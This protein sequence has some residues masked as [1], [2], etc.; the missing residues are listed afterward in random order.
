MSVQ[1]EAVGRSDVP[2]FIMPD[3]FRHE[4]TYFMTV[5]GQN[6][7]PKLP[8]GEYWIDA[9]EAAGWLDDGVFEVV[10]PL[11]SASKTEVELSEEQEGFLEWLVKN[12]VQHVKLL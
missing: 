7:A 2:A 10:S 1:V 6:G 4:I 8:A 12:H 3:R 11:D 9:N 5:P